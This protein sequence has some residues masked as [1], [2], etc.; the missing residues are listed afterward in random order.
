M[1]VR[2]YLQNFTIATIAVAAL[3][4]FYGDE[5][6]Q[7]GPL[8]RVGAPILVTLWWIW[9]LF[10]APRHFFYTLMALFSRTTTSSGRW[11]VYH[12]V[13]LVVYVF[14]ILL[15]LVTFPV[16]MEVVEGLLA[17]V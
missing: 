11:I 4:F 9:A 17:R 12:S 1:R 14:A 5:I 15:L 6:G 13:A 7:N 8:L 3:Y 2:T 10:D 16:V